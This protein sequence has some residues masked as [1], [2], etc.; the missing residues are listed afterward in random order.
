M[1]PLSLG[2]GYLDKKKEK[3]KKVE[4][5]DEEPIND[6]SKNSGEEEK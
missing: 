3:D 6:K 2:Y 4:V 5:H 1:Y